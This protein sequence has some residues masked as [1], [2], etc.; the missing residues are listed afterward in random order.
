MVLQG[1]RMNIRV[2]VSTQSLARLGTVSTL[3]EPC[4]QNPNRLKALFP[5]PYA[6][7]VRFKNVEI[8]D[9]WL[10]LLA[11]GNSRKR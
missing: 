8:F 7:V 6:F 4:K 3:M 2:M 10:K 11:R 5:P 1:Y 9:T